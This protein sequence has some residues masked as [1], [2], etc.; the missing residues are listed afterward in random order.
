VIDTSH[1][2]AHSVGFVIVWLGQAQ[3]IELGGCNVALKRLA[4]WI[5]VLV[6]QL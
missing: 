4:I 6:E 3:I 5:S 2:A 1:F